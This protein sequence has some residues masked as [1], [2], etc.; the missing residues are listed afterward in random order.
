[1]RPLPLLALSALA[2]NPEEPPS[3]VLT[4]TLDG[5]A[6]AA[7]TVVFDELGP[8]PGDTAP[9]SERQA[10]VVLVDAAGACPLLG[11][12]YHLAWLRCE[13]A[14]TG[15]IAE[16]A[17]WPDGELRT[18]WLG[19]TA[20]E[21]ATG[22]Y[23]LA[24]SDGPGVFTARYRAADLSRLAG[25]DAQSCLAACTED[26]DFLWTAS[27]GGQWGELEVGTWDE[28]ALVGSVDLLLS[29]GELAGTFEAG[30]CAM[31]LF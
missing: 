4:G 14:C 24:M 22:H 20:G 8:A 13:S 15:L 28:T 2:C 30:P 21:S 16:Q 11:P 1:M 25:L 3:D 19:V 7:G 26:H 29:T 10:E 9:P 5:Q 6:F 18:L 12:L 31:G 23:D 27:D 17:A